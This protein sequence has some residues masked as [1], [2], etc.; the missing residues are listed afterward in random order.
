MTA[1]RDARQNRRRTI[2]PEPVTE[3]PR[4]IGSRHPASVASHAGCQGRPEGSMPLIALAIVG[5][6]G[7]GYI[8]LMPPFQF[9][10]EHAHFVRSFEVSKGELTAARARAY[11][12]PS[13][14]P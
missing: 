4:T 14:Q 2:V 7:L 11:R 9:N 1:L 13:C 5:L 3:E 6:F 8:W 12:I 10:D